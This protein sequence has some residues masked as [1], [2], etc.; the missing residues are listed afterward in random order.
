MVVGTKFSLPNYQLYGGGNPL[1]ENIDILAAALN[2]LIW[3]FTVRLSQ[4]RK[5]HDSLGE[6]DIL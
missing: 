6:L 4:Q 2:S 3:P 5:R 1:S